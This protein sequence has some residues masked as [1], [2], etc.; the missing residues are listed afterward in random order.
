[1]KVSA[2]SQ[3]FEAQRNCPYLDNG[4]CQVCTCD[5]CENG[6]LMNELREAQKI[7]Y[8]NISPKE[9]SCVRIARNRKRIRDS[10]LD[11]LVERC[12]FE[13]FNVKE[14]WQ[15]TIK[16][17]ALEYLKEYSTKGFFISGQSGSGKTHICTSICNAIMEKGGRL[18]Y[19]QWVR[20]GTR[21]KQLINER[22]EYD[23]EIRKLI[24]IPY[25][26][27]DDLFKQEVTSADIRLVYEIINGRCISDR[28]TIISSE[29][30]LNYI[31]HVREGDGEAVA[32]RIFEMCGKG[33]YCIE[34]SGKD[35]NQRFKAS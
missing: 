20:D 6:F 35:K 7:G 2:E 22:A 33:Q 29:R 30:S 26:Y 12:T 17:T 19:L 13:N 15:S 16:E 28:P 8:S 1:M 24:E 34:V 11:R 18:K 3:D 32:G 31:K 10:G 14:P 25:L 21:L 4:F 27:I 5:K 9:C 23:K